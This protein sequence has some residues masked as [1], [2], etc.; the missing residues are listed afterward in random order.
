MVVEE[1]EIRARQRRPRVHR[2][3]GVRSRHR[4][5]HP[6]DFSRRCTRCR[7]RTI[8]TEMTRL[9]HPEFV[10]CAPQESSVADRHD[11]AD[12]E[13]ACRGGSAG[14]GGVMS[15][16]HGSARPS[17]HLRPAS[18]SRQDASAAST[19]SLRSKARASDELEIRGD[20]REVRWIGRGMTR[21]RIT[22]HRQRGHAPWRLHEGR[23]HR[24]RR[25]RVGLGRR[26]NVGRTHPDRRQRRRSDWRRLSRQPARHDRRHDH[27]RRLRG[28]GDRH[29]DEARAH[30]DRRSGQRFRGA[31]R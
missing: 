26:R 2:A 31:R 27:H 4:G 1:G 20:L 19:N 15:R 29:A 25:K 24:G 21:G 11:H 10:P 7:S 3:T 13:A 9:R 22:D 14:S 17:R 30:R 18:L 8:P 5:V 28:S 16:R 6:S 12:S 23:H